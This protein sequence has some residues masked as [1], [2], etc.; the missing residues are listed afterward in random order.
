M[1][2]CEFLYRISIV[3]P[4]S[5]PGPR[6]SEAF[7]LASCGLSTNVPTRPAEVMHLLDLKNAILDFAVYNSTCAEC[8]SMFTIIVAIDVV[9][10]CGT[11]GASSWSSSAT[12]FSPVHSLRHP[13]CRW[14]VCC[15]LRAISFYAWSRGL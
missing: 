7:S 10:L 1:H 2:S 11:H 9:H 12:R 5:R 13:W 15:P 14:V 6:L 3:D 8:P 4:Y